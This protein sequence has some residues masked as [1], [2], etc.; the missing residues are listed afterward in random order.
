MQIKLQRFFNFLFKSK[1]GKKT[2]ELFIFH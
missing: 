1:L 2:K